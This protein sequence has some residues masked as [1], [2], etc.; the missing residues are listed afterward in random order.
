MFSDRGGNDGVEVA[1]RRFGGSGGDGVRSW[2][3]DSWDSGGE[4]DR[5]GACALYK[6]VWLPPTPT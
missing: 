6:M 4:G 5:C 1:G 2:Q 3:S